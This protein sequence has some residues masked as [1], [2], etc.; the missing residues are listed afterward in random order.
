MSTPRSIASHTQASVAALDDAGAGAVGP[1]VDRSAGPQAFPLPGET[2]DANDLPPWLTPDG[3]A[4]LVRGVAPPRRPVVEHLDGCCRAFRRDL[5]VEVGGL[6]GDDDICTR[7]VRAEHRVAL[8]D[9][10]YV[11][12]R[13]ASEPGP[14]PWGSGPDLGELRDRVAPALRD[15][16]GVRTA[17][18]AARRQPLAV[19]FVMPNMA[20]GGSGGLHS[21]Y[22]DASGMRKL[23]IDAVVYANDHYMRFA[24]L[25]YDDVDEIFVEYASDADDDVERLSRDR[26]VLV[27]THFKSVRLVANV[28]SRRQDFLPAYYVQDY[29]PFFTVNVNGGAPE[30]LEA[31]SSYDLIPGLPLFAKTHW[32][33]NAVGRVRSL[34]VGKVEP[35][36]DETLYTATEGCLRPEG[37]VRVLGMVR[38]RTWRRSPH[39]TLVLLDRLREELGEDVEVHSFGCTDEALQDMTGGWSHGVRHHGI[40]TRQEVADRLH[41]TDVFLDMSVFQGMGRTGFEGMCCGCVPMMPRIGGAHEFAVHDHNAVLIDTGDIDASYRDLRDL[42]RDRERIARLQAAGVEDGRRRSILA[43]V[44]SEYAHFDHWYNRWPQSPAHG[45]DSSSAPG[46]SDATEETT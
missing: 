43:A 34:P 14:G 24:R 21:V 37:P 11:R 15:H 30:S 23:G 28:W 25:A 31:R 2:G 17:F 8:A 20:H 39:A 16:A 5:L 42:V 32:I 4:L 41:Q 29:E 1:L 9:D 36:I 27:A 13:P 46:A 38:P 18:A 26:Q 12:R 44:L 10:V 22:Q 40:L 6:D 33:C 19:G 45:A 7:L 35:G 3:M